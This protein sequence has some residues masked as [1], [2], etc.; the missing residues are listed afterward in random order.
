ML[1]TMTTATI[2]KIKNGKLSLP[3]KVQKSLRETEVAILP[4]ED[5]FYVKKISKPSFE[6]LRPRLLKLGK[7]ISKKD[8]NEAIRWARR[9]GSN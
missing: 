1:N 2:A 9:Q 6:T 3:K 4:L 5:G 7:L 8:I